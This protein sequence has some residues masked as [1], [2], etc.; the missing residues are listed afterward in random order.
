MTDMTDDIEVQCTVDT[1]QLQR[2]T[3]EIGNIAY[4]AP[5]I[6][7]NAANATGKFAMKR[8]NEGIEKEYDITSSAVN[9]RESIKRKSATYANPYTTIKSHSPMTRMTDF[10]VSPRIPAIKGKRPNVYC[11]HVIGTYGNK[12]IVRNGI[13]AFIVR[14]HSG[15]EALVYRV[16]GETYENKSKLRERQEKH[17]DTTRIDEV[18]SPAI[19]FMMLKMFRK[20]EKD[21]ENEL[22]KNVKKQ[23]DSFLKRRQKYDT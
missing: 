13:K 4:K 6:L 11:G 3:E 1:A 8:I 18:H 10:Y 19:P 22:S 7:K 21:I 23:I 15:H 14:F 5:T 16:P 9:L 17:M 12:K 20:H 2:I